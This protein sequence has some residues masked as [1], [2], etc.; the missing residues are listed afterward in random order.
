MLPR[1][2]VC[3]SININRVR[4]CWS[5]P[6]QPE[7][8][9]QHEFSAKPGHWS[10]VHRRQCSV[11]RQ[12][13]HSPRAPPASHETRNYRE[14]VSCRTAAVPGE[15]IQEVPR[16]RGSHKERVQSLEG[17]TGDLIPWDILKLTWDELTKDMFHPMTQQT[18]LTVQPVV[19]W[20]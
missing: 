3:Q 11:A 2:D 7:A 13:W 19:P 8:K 15:E 9:G 18:L 12:P 1:M 14:A 4:Q 6:S 20:E 5:A 10:R 16:W 17:S